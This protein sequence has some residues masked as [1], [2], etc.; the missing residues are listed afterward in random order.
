MGERVTMFITTIAVIILVP[1][2]MTML[3]NGRQRD[4]SKT[5]SEMSTGK[6]V[7]IQKDGVNKLIDVEEYVAGVLPGMVEPK[8]DKDMMEA[9]AVAVRTKVYYAMGE[10]TVVDAGTLEF[11]YLTEEEYKEKLGVQNY[12]QIKRKYEEAVINTAGQTIKN[13]Q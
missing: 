8:A 10:N 13:S 2:I 1:Y 9:Q 7:L 11:T 5:I 3:M 6:D 4:L 12:N